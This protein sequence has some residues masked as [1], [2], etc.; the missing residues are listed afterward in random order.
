MATRALADAEDAFSRL[1]TAAP[2]DEKTQWTK[3]EKNAIERRLADASVMDI[4]EI[5][6]ERGELPQTLFTEDRV[7]VWQRRPLGSWNLTSWPNLMVMTGEC[8]DRWGGLP[9]VSNWR[10]G[11]SCSGCKPMSSAQGLLNPNY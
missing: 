3:D 6:M 8:I 9:M 11:R 5:Q 7:T 4:Y 1:D 10:P 2:A